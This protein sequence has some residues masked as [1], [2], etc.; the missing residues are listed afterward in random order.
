MPSKKIKELDV[1]QLRNECDPKQFNFKTTEEIAKGYVLLS[2]KRA[3]SAIEFGLN[4]KITG[5]N[6][7]VSG[8]TGTGRNT[9]IL[10]AIKAIA[11]KEPVPDDICYLFNFDNPD[12]PTALKLPAGMGV[13]F[14]DDMDEL[15]KELELEVERAFSGKDYE[16]KKKEIVEKIKKE[17]EELSVELEDYARSKGFTIQQ[18]I[19]GLVVL[20]VH[21]D[22]K[23]M[24]EKDF[25]KLAE[26][27]KQQIE[28]EQH[29]I[30]DKIYEFSRKIRNIQLR[31]KNEI[32]ELDKKVAFFTM[33]LLIDDLKLKYKKFAIIIDHLDNAVEDILDNLHYFKKPDDSNQQAIMQISDARSALLN[34]YRVN[35]IIDHS[36]SEG[37]PV[38]V[39]DN[40]TYRNL[41][42]DIEHIARMGVLSTDFTMIKSGAVHRA[43]GGYLV[44][45]AMDVLKEY[46]AW[47]ALKKIIQHR[48]AKIETLSDKYGLISTASLKPEPVSVDIKVILVG[49][50]WLYHLLY[51]HDDDFQKLFKV[52]ADFD[53]ET[54]KTKSMMDKYAKFIATKCKE[55]DLLHLTNDAVA[56]VIDYCT[57]VT[58]HKEKLTTKYLEIEDVVR[59]ASYWAKKSRAKLV[60]KDHIVKALEEKTFR[61]NMVESRIQEMIDE[62]TIF[63]DVTGKIT[64]QING[65]SILDIGDY[66]FGKPSKITAKTY[67]GK[68]E[69]VNIEREADMSGNIHSKGVMI[70]SSF[71][72]HTFGK[73]KLLTFGASICFEQLYSGVDGDSASST[74]LYCILSSLSDLP[75]RQDIAVTGSVS[76]NGE[77]QPVGGINQKIEGFYITCKA[78]GL[79]GTQGVMIP[80]SNVK[81]LMLNDEVVESVKKGKFHIYPVTTISQGIEVL[82]GI[83]AGNK[84]KKGGFSKDTVYYH[85][86]K[87]L[88][89]YADILHKITKDT[90]KD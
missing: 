43:N 4:I 81:H 67:I 35:L 68:G 8:V 75:L 17:K 69:V 27:E 70:L 5:Y 55:E 76:Q 2:Q 20:P 33:W 25:D 84:L 62:G 56:K 53:A 34:K 10:N 46:Y 14:E 32:E 6:I 64:G 79:T 85:V 74:E 45:Q 12:E 66:S 11:K 82:T 9:T 58:E 54:K 71:I 38:I 57:R 47:D 59:E 65:L 50:P 41:V 7:Y 23:A 42:G 3:L 16:D 60:K 83:K 90:K 40:P 30:H 19:T 24:N 72:H 21:K 88:D 36:E 18:S 39:E 22:G 26:S 61:S 31:I 89:Y 52:K 78:K 1:K 28:K 15:V 80:Q 63:V 37:A 73:D 77:I 13:Q 49:N 29:D 48:K 51:I 87:K 86:D 44:L